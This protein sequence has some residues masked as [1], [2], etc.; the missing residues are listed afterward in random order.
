MV[1]LCGDCGG[2]CGV[3][4]GLG[5]GVFGCAG[6]EICEDGAVYGDRY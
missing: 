5:C 6:G 4:G 3:F 2:E 1:F